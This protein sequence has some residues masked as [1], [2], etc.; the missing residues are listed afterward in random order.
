[1]I[2]EDYLERIAR[3]EALSEVLKGRT[4]E[5]DRKVIHAIMLW[6]EYATSANPSAAVSAVIGAIALELPDYADDIRVLDAIHRERDQRLRRGGR[7]SYF[8]PVLQDGDGRYELIERIGSGG[9]GEVFRAIDRKFRGSSRSDVAIKLFI[10]E[11]TVEGIRTRSVDHP[12]VVHVYDEGIDERTERPYIVYEF[13]DGRRL[14]QW[15]TDHELRG[16]EIARIMLRLCEGVSAIHRSM[17]VHRDLK[18][19]N[20]MICGDRPVIM[21]FGIAVTGLDDWNSAGT[22]RILAP[23]LRK[24][25]GASTLVDVFGLGVIMYFLLSKTLPGSAEDEHIDT[26]GAIRDKQ[27]WSIARMCIEQLPA[28]RY[29]SADLLAQDLQAYLQH[30][31]LKY[32]EHQGFVQ[33]STLAVKR[34][35]VQTVLLILLSLSVCWLIWNQSKRID[36]GVHAQ[37]LLHDRLSES[38]EHTEL[39]K[40]ANGY[41]QRVILDSILDMRLRGHEIDPAMYWAISQMGDRVGWKEWTYSTLVSAEGAQMLRTEVERRSSD[42]SESGLSIAYW[43]WLLARVESKTEGIPKEQVLQ[44]YTSARELFVSVIGQDDPLIDQLDEEIAGLS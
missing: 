35:P 1:M 5:D 43:Y 31:P 9:Q 44:A 23:E 19:G 7:D 25:S 14:D 16:P 27:L 11:P 20:I 12:N 24:G 41:S 42:T 38:L 18:P 28:D 15:A 10:R 13:L 26:P 21:D 2:P 32:A 37:A 39:L 17:I 30:R 29:Q 6:L 3:G 34:Y 22:P 33:R 4:D 36:S 8:G 40:L